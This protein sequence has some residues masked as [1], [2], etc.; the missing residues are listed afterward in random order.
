M[1]SPSWKQPHPAGICR[2]VICSLKVVG[3]RVQLRSEAAYLRM[4]H[5][6]PL[7]SP[8]DLN[9]EATRSTL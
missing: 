3:E 1:P 6:F 8:E 9:E 4:A 2:W 5:A 7:R